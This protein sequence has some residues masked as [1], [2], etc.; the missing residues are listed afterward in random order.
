MEM[1]KIFANNLKRIRHE[2]G[3]SQEELA[4]LAGL[5]RTY[6]SS[7]ERC[8]YSVSID[9]IEKLSIVLNINPEKLLKNNKK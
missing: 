8:V 4:Y 9:V 3:M 7:L 1:R 6:I 5:D 2:Q